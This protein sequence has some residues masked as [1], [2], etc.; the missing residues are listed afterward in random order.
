MACFAAM[1]IAR[2][3]ECWSGRS[4]LLRALPLLG[5]LCLA[6]NAGSPPKPQ[7]EAAADAGPSRSA[8][9][10]SSPPRGV[11]V[12][13][14]LSGG[15]RLR[16]FVND[17]EEAT[18]V[19]VGDE[20]PE[21]LPE[22]LKVVLPAVGVARLRVALELTDRRNLAPDVY[23]TVLLPTTKLTVEFGSV[24]GRS[25]RKGPACVLID[26]RSVRR[27]R[28][29]TTD[30]HPGQP[31]DAIDPRLCIPDSRYAGDPSLFL[32][33]SGP[34]PPT[35]GE[36][37]DRQALIYATEPGLYR[38]HDGDEGELRLTFD[39]TWGGLKSPPR[40]CEDLRR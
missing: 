19:G 2:S 15:D 35:G 28:M 11:P 14:L 5:L 1:A 29:C 40:R 17:K 3:G 20:A 26:P 23:L 13:V 21:H 22:P 16:L 27:W 30:V 8:K 39:P 12:E 7:R 18:V 25:S 24:H 36:P 34:L 31:F 38:L 6:A 37:L 10:P 4:V 33:S 9:S 32:I